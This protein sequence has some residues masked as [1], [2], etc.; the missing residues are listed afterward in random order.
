MTKDK[1]LWLYLLRNLVT[2]ENVPLPAY[3]MP[4]AAL[5]AEQVEALTRRA[6]LLSDDWKSGIV[7]PQAVVRLDLPR[8]VTWLRLLCGRWLFVASYDT[9]ASTF[10]CWDITDAF[11][12]V[13]EPAAECCFSGPIKS[14]EL[15]V[16]TDGVVIALAVSSWCESV[17]L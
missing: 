3:L 4:I 2:E 16:Q 15:Q 14:A 12:G 13:T 8:S 10:S 9:R 1:L 5:A 11:Q 17:L 7:K 6:K